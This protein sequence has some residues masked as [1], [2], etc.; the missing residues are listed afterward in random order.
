MLQKEVDRLQKGEEEK[1]EGVATQ[2]KP[3]PSVAETVA[4]P[5]ELDEVVESVAS[6]VA[7]EEVE[8]EGLRERVLFD[9]WMSDLR[10]QMSD[11]DVVVE[12]KIVP[13][14]GILRWWRKRWVWWYHWGREA[15]WLRCRWDQEVW[16]WR[17]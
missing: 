1:D 12:G 9:D 7:S 14:S 4:D 11:D 17:G 6:S 5:S 10:N 16:G 15:M 13:L 2:K 3:E 8:E